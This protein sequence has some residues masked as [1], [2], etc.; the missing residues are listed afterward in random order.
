MRW[1][2]AG[3]TDYT[4][5][6]DLACDCVAAGRRTITVRGE[7]VLGHTGADRPSTVTEIF[8]R[9]ADGDATFAPEGYPLTA[10]LGTA[11]LTTVD[12]VDDHAPLLD[13]LSRRRSR[14]ASAAVFTYRLTWSRDCFCAG[15]LGPFTSTVD[16]GLV[17]TIEADGQPPSWALAVTVDELFA[18]IDDALARHAHVIQVTYDDAL[19]YPRSVA[20]DWDLNTEDDEDRYDVDAL[21]TIP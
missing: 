1:L 16:R 6:F 9:I 10:D 17:R 5:T 7:E 8:A 4:W 3:I 15:P 14:W 12:L 2:A 18:I 13:E 21:E 11:L 19:G 20:I